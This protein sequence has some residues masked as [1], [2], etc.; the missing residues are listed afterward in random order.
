MVGERGT[1]EEPLIALQEGRCARVRR[2]RRDF[3]EREL[4]APSQR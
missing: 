2:S 4:A 1:R 3:R